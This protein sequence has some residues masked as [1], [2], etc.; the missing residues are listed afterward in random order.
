M[1]QVAELLPNK[2]ET[3]GSIVSNKKKEGKKKEI[4]LEMCLASLRP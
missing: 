3:L 1:T 2:C 4:V